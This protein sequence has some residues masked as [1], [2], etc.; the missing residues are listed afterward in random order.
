MSV[1]LFRVGR[2]W[3]YRYQL[4]GKRVQRSTKEIDRQHAEKVAERAFR[5][6][7][8]W[9]RGSKEIPTL[10][11]LVGQWVAIHEASASPAHVKVVETFGRLHLHDLGDVLIDELTTDLVE[12]AR[13][14]HLETHAPVSANQW[15]KVLRLLCSWA[16]RRGI[17]PAMPFHVRVLK[18]QKKPRAILPVDLTMQ[19][20]T[21]IDDRAG[22]RHGV[23]IAV[24]LMIGMGLRE[25]ETRSARWEWFDWE[26]S[27]YT[28]GQ[29]K[30]R[31]AD[32][33]PV[34]AWLLD[35][36]APKRVSAGLM[37]ARPNGKPYGPA[38][39]RSAILA[40]NAAVGAPHVTPHRLRAS[41]ATLLSEAGVPVQN[42][43]RALRHKSLMT[44]AAY[45]ETNMDTVVQ[46]Q[47]RIAEKTR[48]HN[49]STGAPL[50]N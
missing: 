39:T 3:H 29:T 46:G 17:L 25:S 40:A 44:T 20:L 8:L 30:G 1:Q 15:L 4:D 27:T 49:R 16:M 6:A 34:P 32:P 42:I 19:W 31:E 47:Q 24:R 11:E 37:L 38:F 28:P 33:I 18:V 26:R 9:A 48:L 14:R 22:G 36:L 2:V 10:L 12:R 45:L 21:A 23:P 41:F 5:H 7:T 13:A 43:Q 35:Y 50:A